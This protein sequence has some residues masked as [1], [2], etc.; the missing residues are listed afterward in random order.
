MTFHMNQWQIQRGFRH[1]ARNPFETILF[2]FHEEFSEK[3]GKN[4][5]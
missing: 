5:K 2:H 1:F 4:N 3:S